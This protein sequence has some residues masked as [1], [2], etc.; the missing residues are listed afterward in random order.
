MKE[1]LRD[2]SKLKDLAKHPGWSLLLKAFL[3][4][5][6]SERDLTDKLLMKDPQAAMVKGGVIEGL[7]RIENIRLGA[8]RR[9]LS[10]ESAEKAKLES[11]YKEEADL[12]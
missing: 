5:I 8:Y 10:K 1:L 3:S 11:K 2:S 9:A 4:E 6:N 12:F 7:K